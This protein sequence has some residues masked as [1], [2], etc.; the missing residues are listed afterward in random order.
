MRASI[1]LQ[2]AVAAQRCPSRLQRP[3][4]AAAALQRA[5]APAAAPQTVGLRWAAQPDRPLAAGPAAATAAAAAGRRLSLRCS[6]SAQP[7]AASAEPLDTVSEVARQNLKKAANSCRRYGWISFWVQLVL[8]SVAAVVLLFSLA[9]TS[10]N[11]PSIS[12]YLT[13]FGI[14]LGFLSIFW[15]FGYV[16]LSRKLRAFLEAPNLDVAPKIRRSDVITMLERGA[17]IN[18]LGAGLTMLG[19]SATIGVLLAKTL[20]SATVNPFL[21]TSSTNWNPVLAFDVFNVQATTN[22]LLSHF[23]SLVSSLH[24]LRTIANR[25][26][27]AHM[28]A[29][30]GGSSSPKPAAA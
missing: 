20:T 22:A 14:L 11:G 15:S 8:N 24:L 30:G 9:F 5:P 7:V 16:R 28:M 27:P 18:V 10:Q 26:S 2:P 21:A 12:L 25:P 17:T 1:A 4:A 23:F 29:T 6:A 13:F 19:L 3:R